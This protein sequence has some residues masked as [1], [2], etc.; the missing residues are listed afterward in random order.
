MQELMQEPIQEQ[1]R[2][3]CTKAE[4]ELILDMRENRNKY[5]MDKCLSSFA[6]AI[7]QIEQSGFIKGWDCSISKGGEVEFTV[8]VGRQLNKYPW[9]ESFTYTGEV[10]S[11]E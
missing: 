10:R 1:K 11:C 5:I 7:L 3:R 2:F 4:K 8:D 9:L 6:K